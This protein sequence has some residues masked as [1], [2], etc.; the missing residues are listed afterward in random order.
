MSYQGIEALEKIQRYFARRVQGFPQRSPI[1]STISCLGM[2]SMEARIDKQKLVFLGRM[3]RTSANLIA[4]K[5]F[6]W[7]VGNLIFDPHHSY[8]S[9]IYDISTVLK[10]YDLEDYL[11][12]F[13]F[14]GKFPDKISW[15]NLIGTRIQVFEERKHE[16][17]IRNPS[18]GLRRFLKINPGLKMHHLWKVAYTDSSRK[19]EYGTL[20]RIG[21]MQ[22]RPGLCPLCGKLS[23]DR[24]LHISMNCSLTLD[25]RNHL[26]ESLFSYM[27]PV[28]YRDFCDQ[29]D[30]D[31][32]IMLLGGLN[33]I[34]ERLEYQ[35]WINVIRL[36]TKY[37]IKIKD[38]IYS[39]Q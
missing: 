27:P 30:D 13:I 35:A 25:D 2:I 20:I 21:G 28:I 14:T 38:I 26:M 10:K 12:D 15:K 16:R 24:I 11:N 22:A 3:C 17:C 29:I 9:F 32:L 23:Q 7:T 6:L 4:K 5:V 37:F 33:E 18:E 34:T 1:G 36:S 19:M 8:N 39:I 31:I